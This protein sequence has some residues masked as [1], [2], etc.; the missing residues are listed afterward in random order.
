MSLVIPRKGK[1]LYPNASIGGGRFLTLKILYVYP[2]IEMGGRI[3]IY[4]L[5]F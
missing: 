2:F 5:K 3:F 4:L 1:S